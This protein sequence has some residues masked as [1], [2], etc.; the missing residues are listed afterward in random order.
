MTS[1]IVVSFGKNDQGPYLMI[2]K[3]YFDRDGN[4]DHADIVYEEDS[5]GSE[6]IVSSRDIHS[7]K[8]LTVDN[9]I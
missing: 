1:R 6:V 5:K 7:M 8:I 3:E 9:R 4:V 2:I